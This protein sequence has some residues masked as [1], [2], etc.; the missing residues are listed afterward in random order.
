MY[1]LIC[2]LLVSAI[3]KLLDSAS[4]FLKMAFG[5]KVYLKRGGYKQALADFRALDPTDVRKLDVV[6]FCMILRRIDG[7]ISKS[8]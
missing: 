3:D 4:F 6:S 8:R 7:I 2:F 1:D 5:E